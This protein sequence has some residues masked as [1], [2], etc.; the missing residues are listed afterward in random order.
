M[1]NP[2]SY[3]FMITVE[4]YEEKDRFEKFYVCLNA[5]KTGFLSGCGSVVGLEGP[6]R[7]YCLQP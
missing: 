7:V 4:D 5:S 2:G 3:V 6:T 1:A